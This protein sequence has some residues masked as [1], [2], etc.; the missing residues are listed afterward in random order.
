MECFAT[1]TDR[2]VC[3]ADGSDGADDAADGDGWLGPHAAAD[4]RWERD[5]ALQLEI[6]E[7]SGRMT[8]RSGLGSGA[9][10]LIGRRYT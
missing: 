9:I 1:T 4:A 10:E 2:T 8:A 6:Q 5:V 3:A 7:A